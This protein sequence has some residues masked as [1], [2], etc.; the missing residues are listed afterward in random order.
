MDRVDEEI[1]L[2]MPAWR[3]EMMR[4]LDTPQR[5]TPSGLAEWQRKWWNACWEQHYR[6]FE[7]EDKARKAE[8][9]AMKEA[10]RRKELER[11]KE[12]EVQRIRNLS[13]EQ[14]IQE[15]RIPV[16]TIRYALLDE[17]WNQRSTSWVVAKARAKGGLG[18]WELRDLAMKEACIPRDLKRLSEWT[19]FQL[20]ESISYVAKAKGYAELSPRGKELEQS[21]RDELAKRGPYSK[22]E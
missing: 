10:Q 3:E 13:D 1:S 4:I 9:R 20:E 18:A 22:P 15:C 19:I 14:L 5:P 8:L 11:L 12:A 2:L 6:P 17:E 7:E 16:D 21:L